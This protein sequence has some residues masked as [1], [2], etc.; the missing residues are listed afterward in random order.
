MMYMKKKIIIVTISIT[1]L[2]IIGLVSYSND[3]IRF[4]ISYEYINAVEYSNGKKIKV[5]I[6]L[7]NQIKYLN[8][9]DIITFLKEGTGIIYFG[10]NTCPW[11]R[12][13]VE[14]LLEVADENSIDK[15]YYV[16]IH[17]ISK[18]KKEIINILDDYLRLDEET[19]TK[20]LAVPD[21]Y[22]IK[23]GKILTHHIGTVDS[24]KNPYLGMNNKQKEE[25]KRIYNEGIEAI[26]N[27]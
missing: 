15:V 27:E 6:P 1:L 14:P 23:N 2:L 19:N 18:I 26:N 10:Y 13:I 24:Y 12:N 22:F 11:C 8:N 16:D 3:A 4:K 17:H 5:S 20:V 7:N 9:N 25:L 21:V